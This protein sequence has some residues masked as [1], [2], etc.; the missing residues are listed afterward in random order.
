MRYEPPEV[1]I[2][3]LLSLAGALLTA[4]LAWD[5]LRRTAPADA[6]SRGEPR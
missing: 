4:A 1:R 2:G 3:W 6:A 5:A